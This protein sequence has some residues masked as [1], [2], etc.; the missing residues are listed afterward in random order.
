[1]QPHPL[2]RITRVPPAIVAPPVLNALSSIACD[3]QLRPNSS[4]RATSLWPSS[5]EGPSHDFISTRLFHVTLTYIGLPMKSRC[6]LIHPLFVSALQRS[7]VVSVE[8]SRIKVPH[9]FTG[10]SLV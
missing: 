10:V 6:I 7:S 2:S 3:P 1:M 9:L 8:P 4:F 5:G